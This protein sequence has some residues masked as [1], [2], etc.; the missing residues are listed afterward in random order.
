MIHSPLTEPTNERAT[1]GQGYDGES[2]LLLYCL[3]E[4]LHFDLRPE[5]H[6]FHAIPNALE[7][8]MSPALPPTQRTTTTLVP[9]IPSTSLGGAADPYLS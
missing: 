2:H 6:N 5:R 7:I 9:H 8:K 3:D 1:Q 4:Y